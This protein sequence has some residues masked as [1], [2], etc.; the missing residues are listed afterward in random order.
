MREHRGKQVELV[1]DEAVKRDVCHVCIGFQFGKDIFLRTTTIVKLNDLSGACGFVGK[2]Y[3]VG[4]AELQRNKEVKLHGFFGLYRL[5]GAHEK[6]ASGIVPGFWFPG[7]LEASGNGSAG[8]PA[9]PRFDLALE[10]HEPFERNG[11]GEL[12]G[13]IDEHGDDFLAEESAVH[14]Y[15]DSDAGQR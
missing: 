4:K 6:E 5:F 9:P 1:G 7:F 10:F 11:D 8:R 15:F 14:A 13:A 3:L 2:D 12:N